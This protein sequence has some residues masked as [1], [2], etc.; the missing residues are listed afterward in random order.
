MGTLATAYN[1]M[2]HSNGNKI[3]IPQVDPTGYTYINLL[4]D[5]TEKALSKMPGNVNVLMQMRFEI[6][7]KHCMM[8]NDDDSV[9]EM[10]KIH[11]SKLVINLHVS[12]MEIILADEENISVNVRVMN[13]EDNLG[14]EQIP[15]RAVVDLGESD[16]DY[17]DS[18]S[19]ST[20]K[21]NLRSDTEEE[22]VDERP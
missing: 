3:R 1:I 20:Q 10:F 5:V 22:V 21:H 11:K 14:I 2:V 8:N 17:G 6:P 9:A 15:S 13:K 16:D 12:D 7:K 19:D 4:F 18:S